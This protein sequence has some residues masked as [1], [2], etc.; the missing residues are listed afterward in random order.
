MLSLSIKNYSLF[1]MLYELI[2]IYECGYKLL[3]TWPRVKC[4]QTSLLPKMAAA[5]STGRGVEEWRCELQP[6]CPAV[7]KLDVRCP[8]IC[9]FRLWTRGGEIQGGV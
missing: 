7:P 6:V 8:E 2:V 3:K 9:E 4:Y 1:I 5:L